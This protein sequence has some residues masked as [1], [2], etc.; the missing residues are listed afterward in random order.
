MEDKCMVFWLAGRKIFSGLLPLLAMGAAANLFA[1]DSDLPPV[2]DTLVRVQ[3]REAILKDATDEGKR[4]TDWIAS[5]MEAKERKARLELDVIRKTVQAQEMK[6]LEEERERRRRDD[7]YRRS[8]GEY[9]PPRKDSDTAARTIKLDFQ[10]PEI[11]TYETVST[12][13][14]KHKELADSVTAYLSKLDRD[15]DGKLTGEDYADAGATV[16]G[17]AKLLQPVDSNGDGYLTQRELETAFEIPR[18]AVSARRDGREVSQTSDFRIKQFDKD[19]NGELST[20]EYK[21]MVMTYVEAGR[22]AATSAA[23][24][25]QAATALSQARV[26][27]AARF[28][29][30]DVAPQSAPEPKP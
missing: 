5:F 20:Q 11:T 24:Y 28:A 10:V 7:D 14:E 17:V 16:L 3:S 1:E 22:R 8:I 6:R 21:S 23:F 26:V 4:T 19:N 29:D 25:K 18:N 2:T 27:S 9:V 15:G 12:V 30:L 13:Y